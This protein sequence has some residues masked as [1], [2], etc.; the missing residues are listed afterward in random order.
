[1]FV[2]NVRCPVSECGWLEF[3]PA[4][5]IQP[6]HKVHVLHSLSCRAFY[7]VVYD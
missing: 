1:M 2:L 5:L 7:Q 6:E 3:Q 4:C